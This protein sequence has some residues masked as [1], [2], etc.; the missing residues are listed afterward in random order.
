[1]KRYRYR[2]DD[3]GVLRDGQSLRVPMTMM[4]GLDPIQRSVRDASTHRPGFRA[5]D[6]RPG[7]RTLTDTGAADH[8]R[9][10]AYI[11]AD[12]ALCDAWRTPPPVGLTRRDDAPPTGE[13]FETAL[14][15]AHRDYHHDLVNAW[16]PGW[17][18]VADAVRACTACGGS[19]LD[20]D[21][22]KCEHCHGSG[23]EP[24]STEPEPTRGDARSV[25]QTMQDHAQRMDALYQEH[26]AELREAWR[27]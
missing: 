11:D 12:R 7:F 22:Y 19:G 2:H 8:A 26:D 24:H 3:D 4:D 9:E 16:R 27:G 10:Q 18:A 21:A 14:A 6:H 5:A 1:M 20:E 17:R 23:Y 25:Q 15:D 13:H